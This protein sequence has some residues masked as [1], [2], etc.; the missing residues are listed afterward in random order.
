MIRAAIEFSFCLLEMISVTLLVQK[1]F[2]LRSRC[3]VHSGIC[4]YRIFD[5]VLDG[6]SGA[7]D[8]VYAYEYDGD[9]PLLFSR[10]NKNAHC[11]YFGVL[12]R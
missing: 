7:V 1:F 9:D 4:A 3:T 11:D 8:S 10:Q 12:H 5:G 6:G 2:V